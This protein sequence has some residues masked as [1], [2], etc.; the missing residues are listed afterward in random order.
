MSFPSIG[1]FRHIARFNVVRYSR[2]K[3]QKFHMDYVC[4]IYREVFGR[5]KRCLRHI[6]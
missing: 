1:L 5:I 2:P 6:T 3:Y 4:G